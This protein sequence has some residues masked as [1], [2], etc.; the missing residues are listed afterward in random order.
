MKKRKMAGVLLG[1]L[2]VLG[3][4]PA[5]EAVAPEQFHFHVEMEPR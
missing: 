1:L 5:T 3:S 4:S 2:L